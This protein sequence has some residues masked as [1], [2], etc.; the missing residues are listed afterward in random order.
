MQPP[1]KIR[2]SLRKMRRDFYYE[3]KTTMNSFNELDLPE[4]LQAALVKMEFN[5]PTPIQ[6]QA[7]PL[8]LEGNDI[9]GSAQTGTGKT[10]AFGIPMI[11]H[12]M[13]N[14][15]SVAIVMTPTR[16][17][18]VQ[19]MQMMKKLLNHDNAIK[20]ALLIGGENMFR[21]FSQLEN[22]PRIIVGTPGRIND[23][24]SR[25]SLNLSQADFL[26]LDETDR[27]LDMGFGVQ[28]DKIL[29]YMSNKD[30]RQTLLFSATLPNHIVRL[31]D[32]YMNDPVRV[33]VGSTHKPITAIKQ[34]VIHVGQPQKYDAL[35]QQLDARTGSIIVFVRTKH[36]CDRIARKLERESH[37]AAAIHG[38]L[39]QNK[40]DKVIRL[41]REKRIRVL[42]ATDVAARGLDIPH[43]EHVINYDLPQ[44]PEDYIHR[45]GRTA[46]AGAEGEALCFISPEE[47]DK[48]AAIERLIKGGDVEQQ[49]RSKKSSGRNRHKNS[50]GFGRKNEGHGRRPGYEMRAGGQQQDRQRKTH[51]KGQSWQRAH[52]EAKATAAQNGDTAPQFRPERQ[53][54]AERP[55]RNDAQR[56][57]RKF[58]RRDEK[59]SF[60]DRDSKPWQK[61]DRDDNRG[62]KR[63]EKKKRFDRQDG[64]RSENRFE[65]KPWQKRER[66][67]GGDKPWQ[68]KR[69][70]GFEKKPW[71]KREGG[72]D[73]PYQKRDRAEG[74]FEKKPWQKREG[75]NDRPFKKRDRAEGGDRPYVKRERSEGGEKPWQK[76]REGGFEKKPWQK[77][78]GGSDRPYQKRE[79]N[80]EGRSDR[81]YA[82][83]RDAK[84]GGG[85][86]TLRGGKPTFQQ[87][88]AGKPRFDA[89]KP[90]KRSDRNA[91]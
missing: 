28:I 11:A 83:K 55:A 37:S 12:L 20:T 29:T 47:G 90:F 16:E 6:A 60:R 58:E 9:L 35:I 26:V 19:V 44:S 89:D 32:K 81:P 39:R 79:R 88:P 82:Q 43:I 23:H 14:E 62:E 78:E 22:D 71:Q 67:E 21:Q 13:K 77:R 64:E 34:E 33:A 68:K 73:R 2:P 27:M 4:A 59:K 54:R 70:G 3:G 85:K 86:V 46:R 80:N 41:F 18:A 25:K 53:E 61:R 15:N 74:G 65:K 1:A 30:Q 75:G 87:R 66:S 52:D 8:A 17:L 5:T 10:A 7:I 38:D 42:I 31:A 69:E 50:S 51:R 49:P 48:W 63:F 24:L 57:E 84:S 91:G 72:S 40:R 36:G 56:F 76:K 45:I